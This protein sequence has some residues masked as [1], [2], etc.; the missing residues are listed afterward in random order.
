VSARKTEAKDPSIPVP[1]GEAVFRF[2]VPPDVRWIVQTLEEAGYE[3]WAVGG[4]VRDVLLGIPSED[5]DLAT[6][7]TPAQ[8]RR[9][10]RRT[11]PIGLRH[12]TVGVL[13][14]NGTLYEVTTFRRDV[15]TTG[16]HAVV[17]FADRIED[18]LSRRDFTINA[19]AWH[20]LREELYDPFGGVADL[21]ARVLR[22]VG[23]PEHRFEEDYLRVLRAL[24]FAGRF[25]L[26]IAGGTWVAIGASTGGLHVLSRER[27]REELMKVL[28]ADPEPSH[29]LELYRT[30]GVLAAVAPELIATVGLDVPGGPSELDAWSYGMAVAEML[31][32]SRPLLRLVALLQGVGLPDSESASGPATQPQDARPSG[33]QTGAGS[34]GAWRTEEAAARAAAFMIRLRFSNAQVELAT[35]L[36]GAGPVPLVGDGPS[37]RRWLSRVGPERLPQV[38]RLWIARARV[39][40]RYALSDPVAP[41]VSWRALRREIQ[42]RP[43]LTLG[44]LEFDGRDLMRLGLKPGPQFRAILLRLL[45]CVLEDP[46]LNRRE[47]LADL[48]RRT[49]SLAAGADAGHDVDRDNE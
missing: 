2:A 17:E 1:A 12:G 30:S 48:A 4:A 22:T 16:R 8:V 9:I 37:R 10:F 7:A 32:T 24:R 27:V 31:P 29:A 5:W 20:P 14:R 3:T 39:L 25:G 33:L 28:G 47:T 26:E 34:G 35:S 43:P 6:R 45:E 13:A 23:D 21:E 41:Q 44:D 42:G 49:P 36:L 40:A 38:V 18:D 15:I 19:I 46:S 11:V